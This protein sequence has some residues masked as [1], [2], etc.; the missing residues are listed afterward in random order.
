MRHQGPRPVGEQGIIFCLCGS[1]PIGI[2]ECLADS[3]GMRDKSLAVAATMAYF[4][5]G[6]S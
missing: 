2:G 6:K 1:P 4:L 3:G 5:L